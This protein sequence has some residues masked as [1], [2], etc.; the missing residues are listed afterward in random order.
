ML[1]M[2]SGKGHMTEG[3]ELPNQVVIRTHREKESYKSFVIL[4]ADTNK[5]VE[6]KEKIKQEYLRGTRKLLETKLYT[7]NLVKWINIWVVSHE[8]Y[9]GLF[10]KR[11]REELKQ[12]DP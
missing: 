12:M 11:T 8:G 4:E 2:K 6:R 3:F 10:L 5:Q 9:W 7:R 1:A